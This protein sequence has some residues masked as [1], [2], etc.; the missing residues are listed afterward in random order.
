M[1]TLARF[2]PRRSLPRLAALVL[3]CTAPFAL[4]QQAGAESEADPPGRVGYL[5]Y[6]QGSVVFAPE[7]EEEWVELPQNRPLTTGDRVWSDRGARA[8]VHWVRPRCTW[9]AKA[10]SA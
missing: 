1:D 8:E 2:R 4:A 6:R 3:L 9:T 7:G 5:S 10:T